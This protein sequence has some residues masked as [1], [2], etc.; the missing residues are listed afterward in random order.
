MNILSTQIY[1]DKGGFIEIGSTHIAPTAKVPLSF[2]QLIQT[3]N[4][5]S[6]CDKTVWYP[7]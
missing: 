5:T 2:H 3:I 1:Y 7:I 6:N 4:S